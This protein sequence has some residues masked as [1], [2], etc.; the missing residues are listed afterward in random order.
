MPVKLLMTSCQSTTDMVAVHGVSKDLFTHFREYVIDEESL[1][2][3]RG[4]TSGALVGHRIAAR[5]GWS[6]GDHVVLQELGGISFDICG[7]F[8]TPGTPDDFL[9]LVGRRFLQEAT[10]SQGLSTQVLV[11]L[12]P[13]ADASATCREIEELPLAT[14]VT[15]EME[16]AFLATSLDQLKDLVSISRLVIATIALVTLIAIGNAISIAT[17]ERSSEIG[18]LR[19]LGFQ[20]G[21]ILQM[22]VLEGVLQTAIGGVLGCLVTEAVIAA[23]IIKP[24]ST[25]GISVQI[26][27]GLGPWSLA[28]AGI[29]AAGVIGSLIP[30]W[31]L[32]RVNIIDAI[33]RED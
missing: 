24:V 14:N 33:R 19:T 3:F 10:D 13:D 20:K 16:E 23:N 9:I 32:S 8:V 17:R 29:A 30:A 18:I 27:S 1:Q 4:E 26:A 6:D 25:C 28:L 11:R 21:T 7:I 12:V 5:Y 31:Q 22:V 2:K 15:A